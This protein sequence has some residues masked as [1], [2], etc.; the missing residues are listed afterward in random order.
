MTDEH[1]VTVKDIIDL[2]DYN[3]EGRCN[4]RVID[5]ESRGDGSLIQT[6]S[7][8][9]E[10]LAKLPVDCLDVKGNVIVMYLNTDAVNEAWRKFSGGV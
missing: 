8:L 4:I 9:L 6:D 10:F 1:R 3:R 2:L 7:V 5:S